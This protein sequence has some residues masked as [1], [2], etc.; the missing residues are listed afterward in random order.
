MAETTKNRVAAQSV[1]GSII[2]FRA[3]SPKDAEGKQAV[4]GEVTV[5][6]SR[7]PAAMLALAAAK[8][9]GTYA[10]GRYTRTSPEQDQPDVVAE[11]A[12]LEQEFLAG[13]F[14][15]G[16]ESSAQPSPFHEALATH[17]NLP[18]ASIEDEIKAR[19]E[20]FTKA[21]LAELR[22]FPVIDALTAR[23]TKERAA[24]AEKAARDRGK[25]AG[26]GSD[27]FAGLFTTQA[28]PA[29]AAAQ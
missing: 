25:A 13:T 16:R 19:P 29:Q 7:F 18:I 14:E 6:T 8:G 23:I 9:F 3:F 1:V 21:K 24:L 11:V 27:P 20:V 26:A 5:D 28:E 17:L 2:T 12:R 10:A 4:S 15:P 22:R